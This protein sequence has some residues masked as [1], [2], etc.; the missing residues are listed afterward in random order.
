MRAKIEG[1]LQLILERRAALRSTPDHAARHLAAAGL[2]RC[3]A[4][5]KGILA[6]EDVGLAFL[7]GILTRQLFEVWLVSLHVLLRG[8]AALSEVLG[9]DIHWK[10]LL[11]KRLDLGIQYHENWEGK[12]SKL[13]F[14]AMAKELRPLLTSAGEEGTSSGALTYDVVYRTQSLFAVHAGLATLGAHVVYGDE[15]W[16]VEPNPEPPFPTPAQTPALLT[17]HLAQYVFKAFGLNAGGLE[18]LWRDI[19]HS[20]AEEPGRDTEGA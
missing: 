9:D 20:S 15:Y 10:R 12:I 17:A 11:S 7:A 18:P 5:V 4:L 8:D 3:C 14:E 13:N 16:E 1:L 19:M 6:L 2:M